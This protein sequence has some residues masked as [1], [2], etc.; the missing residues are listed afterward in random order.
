MGLFDAPPSRDARGGVIVLHGARGI[1][2]YVQEVCGRLASVGYRAVAPN[3]FHRS[4]DRPFGYDEDIR[5]HLAGLSENGQLDDLD[6]TLAYLKD[7]GF[8]PASIGTVGFCMGGSTAFL[9]GCRRPHGAAVSF[10]GA[11]AGATNLGLSPLVD[12]AG[13]L[14]TPW[15]GLFGDHDPTIAVEEVEDLRGA[16]AEAGTSFEIVR[17]ADAGH[18]FHEDTRADLY[19]EASARD[20]WHRTLEWFDHALSKT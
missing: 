13:E 8:E 12:Y 17:Y 19:H 15:L 9:A 10:Y 2:D 1:N 11:I 4:S 20:A 18:G 6:A 3:L 5:S 7:V 16:L 14:S